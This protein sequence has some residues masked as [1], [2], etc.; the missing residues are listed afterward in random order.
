MCSALGTCKNGW[1]RD[2]TLYLSKIHVLQLFI[3]L[4]KYVDVVFLQNGNVMTPSVK[5]GDKVLL[6]EYGGTKVVLEEQVSLYHL[7]LNC[8]KMWDLSLIVG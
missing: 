1:Q 8:C 2:Q 7:H 4:A 3:L 5:V 6:P